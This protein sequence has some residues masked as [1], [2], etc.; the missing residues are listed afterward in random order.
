V[1]VVVV[2]VAVVVVVV[3]V[4]VVAVTPIHVRTSVPWVPGSH[5]TAF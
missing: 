1:V 4:V 2:V 3:V 5:V